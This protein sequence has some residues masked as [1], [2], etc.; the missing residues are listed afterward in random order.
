MR[1]RDGV[2]WFHAEER[3]S[4][5]LY[6]DDLRLYCGLDFDCSTVGHRALFAKEADFA[7]LLWDDLTLR[8]LG[9]AKL[10]GDT[11]LTK[12]TAPHGWLPV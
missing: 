11:D 3:C 9:N 2:G 5:C 6:F 1:S 8:R 10:G 4:R 12:K 7:V